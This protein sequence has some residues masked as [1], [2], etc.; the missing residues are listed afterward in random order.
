MAPANRLQAGSTAAP[1]ELVAD[2][3]GPDHRLRAQG[4]QWQVRTH[5]PERKQ[6]GRRRTDKPEAFETA[7]QGNR[8]RVTGAKGKPRNRGR[9][10]RWERTLAHVCATGGGVNVAQSQ[11]LRGAA[12]NP[13]RWLGKLFGM[14]RPRTGAGLFAL[15]LRRGTAWIAWRRPPTQFQPA[16]QATPLSMLS[17]PSISPGLGKHPLL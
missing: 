16:N 11:V 2:K 5:L 15:F 1:E 17:D 8:R 9:R 4:A 3:G 7:G 10:E 13:G 12:G 6:T 14:S